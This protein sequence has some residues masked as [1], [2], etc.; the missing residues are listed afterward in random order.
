M[1]LW[2]FFRLSVMFLLDFGN[3]PTVEYFCLSSVNIWISLWTDN[4]LSQVKGRIKDGIGKLFFAANIKCLEQ[5][6]MNISTNSPSSLR[7]EAICD[8]P[9]GIL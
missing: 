4:K 9:S 3:V 2:V 6:P 1:Y 5:L 7:E 8:C